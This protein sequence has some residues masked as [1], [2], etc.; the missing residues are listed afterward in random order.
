MT[1]VEHEGLSLHLIDI[2]SAYL[3]DALDNDIC[4]KLPKRYNLSNNAYF[5]EEYSL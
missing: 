5:R 2:V 3:Y 4:M 1:F